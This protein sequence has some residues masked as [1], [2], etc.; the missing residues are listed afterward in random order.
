MLN[1]MQKICKMRFFHFLSHNAIL[2]CSFMLDI[3][4]D[5]HPAGPFTKITS[6]HFLS[7]NAILGCSFMLDF[8]IDIHPAGP[9]RGFHQI[10]TYISSLQVSSCVSVGVKSVTYLTSGSFIHESPHEGSTNRSKSRPN[11]NLPWFSVH[12]QLY[13]FYAYQNT[14]YPIVVHPKSVNP[15]APRVP[16]CT[17]SLTLPERQ[18]LG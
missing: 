6:F 18:N 14:Q 8:Y 11:E 10:S 12:F 9:F 7:H 1:N 15:Q 2:G 17:D 5:I 4:I 3:Y 16:K 13:I